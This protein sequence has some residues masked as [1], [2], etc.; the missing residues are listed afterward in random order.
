MR[1]A[2]LFSAFSLIAA[3]L[4]FASH[5]ALASTKT[6]SYTGGSQ[7]FLVPGDV[8]SIGIDIIGGTGAK[9]ATSGGNGGLAAEVVGTITV[10]P[11]ETL[12]IN[13]G[14]SG[15][16]GTDGGAGGFNGGADGGS[17]TNDGGGGGGA[18]DIRTSPFALDQRLA[19]AGGGGGGGGKG[20]GNGGGG[21]AT[22]T[23]G[24]VGGTTGSGSGGGGGG[25]ST[26]GIGGGGASTG[27]AGAQGSGG[28][29]ADGSN[30][31]GGGGGGRYGGGGGG[32]TSTTTLGGGGGG[33]G[34]SFAPGTPTISTISGFVPGSV[35]LTYTT[36]DT[37]PPT[38]TLTAPTDGSTTSD[39]TP[40]FSGVAGTAAGDDQST[41]NVAV[42]SG[43]SAGGTPV[44]VLPVT[45]QGG[46][47][48]SVAPSTALAQGTYT[49]QASEQDAS[50]NIGYS[51]PATF[52]VDT[53]APV[54][55]LTR[56]PKAR[57]T[58]RKAV[59]DFTS[60]DA[61]AVT[62]SCGRDAQPAADCSSLTVTYTK[63]RQGKHVF[64]LIV[65]DAA[66]NQT[67]KDFR[68]RIV[69]P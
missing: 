36:N 59:F 24:T 66:G 2:S 61:T 41:V 39:T 53:T 33:G 68:W 14:G 45:P 52:T 15:D 60:T 23:D 22:G 62:Y 18:T 46:G 43:T 13:V 47:V 32:S 42:Y 57:T 38:I 27:S 9:G 51:S 40:T 55:Q 31:G 5:P 48:Y 12:Q 10:T 16:L 63:L 54:V 29:G 20:S 3:V 25:T 19:V 30:G 6:F 17:G 64:H 28:N 67:H 44:Q 49:A 11:G 21:G 35:S 7:T 26:G 1:R 58:S 69:A 65:T 37:T 8:S 4:V 56:H 50:N 34:S